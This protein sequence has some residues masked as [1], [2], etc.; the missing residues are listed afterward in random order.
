MLI[1]ESR[2]AKMLIVPTENLANLVYRAVRKGKTRY[3]YV[4]GAYDAGGGIILSLAAVDWAKA[5]LSYINPH[6]RH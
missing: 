4:A 2:D 5:K 1:A 6:W 3:N